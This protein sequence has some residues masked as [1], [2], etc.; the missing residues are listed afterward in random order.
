MELVV[1]V[2]ELFHVYNVFHSV[3]VPFIL[4]LPLS[5]LPFCHSLS[6][7]CAWSRGVS[8]CFSI[9]SLPWAEYYFWAKL[10]N[11]AVI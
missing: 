6:S 9:F 1:L 3:S 7:P 8:F 10:L 2:K 5:T 4:S 11:V